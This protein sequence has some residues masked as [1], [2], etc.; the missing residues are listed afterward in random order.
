MEIVKTLNVKLEGDNVKNFISALNKITNDQQKAGFSNSSLK[1]DELK[2]IKDLN[3]KVG[4][5]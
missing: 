1:A 2:V 4:N 5:Q 3:E